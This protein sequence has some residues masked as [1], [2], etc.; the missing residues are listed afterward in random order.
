MRLQVGLQ[1]RV[2]GF[3][4]RNDVL[5]HEFQLLPRRRRTIG[6]VTV[7]ALGERFAIEDFLADRFVDQAIEFGAHRRPLVH[8]RE[9]GGQ[10]LDPGLADH[11]RC[12]ARKR[13]CP[14]ANHAPANSTAPSS[15]EVQQRLAKKLASLRG[16]HWEGADAGGVYQIGDV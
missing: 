9:A 8:A 14:R 16:P 2:G 10:V 11:D 15:E 13:R 4:H 5:R 3:R 1:L 6:V 7:Q 12:P